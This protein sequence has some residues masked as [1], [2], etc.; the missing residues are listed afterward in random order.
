[1]WFRI[2]RKR[3]ERIGES[4]LKAGTHG[5]TAGVMAAWENSGSGK[6]GRDGRHCWD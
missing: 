2:R 1:M 6:E 4:A 5:R 3:E